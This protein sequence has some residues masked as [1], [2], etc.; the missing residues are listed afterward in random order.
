MSVPTKK[1]TLD[2]REYLDDLL[3]SADKI[4]VKI[5]KAIL[6]KEIDKDETYVHVDE[7]FI[8]KETGETKALVWRINEWR[9]DYRRFLNLKA[10][11][12][13]RRQQ[14]WL[15]ASNT[16]TVALELARLCGIKDKSIMQSVAK[17]LVNKKA[18]DAIEKL[19]L[20]GLKLDA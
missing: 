3:G 7:P 15:D 5:S 1:I 9:T 4:A 13:K 12:E 20:R 16:D 17:E 8:D 18:T 6:I 14:Y 10:E 2:L 11:S 19:G